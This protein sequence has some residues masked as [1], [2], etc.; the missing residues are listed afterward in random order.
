MM[1]NDP[2][3]GEHSIPIDVTWHENFYSKYSKNS[4]K[5]FHGFLE[6]NH[7]EKDLLFTWAFSNIKSFG[8]FFHIISLARNT[9][10]KNGITV[11]VFE[12][13]ENIL[14]M[15]KNYQHF[16]YGIWFVDNFVYCTSVNYV[17]WTFHKWLGH[18]STNLL[19]TSLSKLSS[20]E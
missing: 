5:Q 15:S 20:H 1:L 10:E 12:R 13:V 2:K 8:W 7:V 14:R 9:E 19:I 3:N 18:F 17:T 6:P 16:T 11:D 4:W